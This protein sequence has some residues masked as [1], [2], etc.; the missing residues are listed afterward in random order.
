MTLRPVTRELA[1]DLRLPVDQGLLVVGLDVNSPGAELGIK[2]KDV[3]FQM[4]KY[5]VRNLDQLG[6]ILENVRPGQSVKIGI[7]RGSVQAWATITARA[8]SK[9]PKKAL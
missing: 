1:S 4:G 2:L 3:I 5:Y 6:V 8:E 9:K 7:V